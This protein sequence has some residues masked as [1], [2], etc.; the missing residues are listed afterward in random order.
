MCA[1][2]LSSKR[3]VREAHRTMLSEIVS[4]ISLFQSQMV[5][6]IWTYISRVDGDKGAHSVTGNDFVRSKIAFFGGSGTISS[7]K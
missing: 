2:L 5:Q 6:I 1:A 7:P 3:I 4:F